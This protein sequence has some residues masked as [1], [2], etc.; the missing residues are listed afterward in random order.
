MNK[1]K[2]ILKKPFGV[3]KRLESVLLIQNKTLLGLKKT[4]KGLI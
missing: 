4:P 3:F 1:Y 2:E